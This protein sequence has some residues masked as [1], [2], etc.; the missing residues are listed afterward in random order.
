VALH[1]PASAAG[2]DGVWSPHETASLV[3]ELM[4]RCPGLSRETAEYLLR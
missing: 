1:S 4:R 3:V 2:D